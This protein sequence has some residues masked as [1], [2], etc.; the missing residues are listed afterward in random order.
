M[1][2]VYII[3][4]VGLI[5][6]FL[7]YYF[8]HKNYSK[9]FG[10][11]IILNGPSVAGKSSIQKKIQESF[12]QLYLTAGLDSFVVNTLG[13]KISSE[14][15]GVLVSKLIMS[16]DQEGNP[17]AEWHIGPLGKKVFKGMHRA[18]AAFAGVGNN[19]VVDYIMYS[20][21]LL[22]DLVKV[23]KNYKVYFVGVR[24]PLEI[25]E[26]REKERNTSPIGHA[27][28]HYNIVHTHDIYDLEVD[29]SQLTAEECAEK[30]KK[31]IEK[32]PEPEAFN[33]LQ[34]KFGI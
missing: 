18:I 14:I 10:T 16:T 15:N 5:F 27:R 17:V 34:K 24:I 7:S 1:K 33:R 19:L 32:N 20:Q 31:F 13:N 4:F 26:Q 23:L 3:F 2:K 11:I 21:D 9:N 29:T 28:S 12:D 30:I 22:V 6:S 25:L 8:Y